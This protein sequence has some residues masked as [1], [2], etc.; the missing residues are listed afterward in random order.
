MEE[1]KRYLALA[2]TGRTSVRAKSSKS[3]PLSWIYGGREPGGGDGGID[4]ILTK[5]NRKIAVRRKRYKQPVGP[6]VVRDLWG[7]MNVNDYKEGCIVTTTGFTKGVKDFVEG[8]NIRLI[9]L[10][11]ILRTV[12]DSSYLDRKMSD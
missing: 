10:N 4:I 9:D 5:P 12:K 7:T 2:K 8:K 1:K 3:I 6:H 11:D